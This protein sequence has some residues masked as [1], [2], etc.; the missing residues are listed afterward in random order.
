MGTIASILQMGT[1]KPPGPRG[2][3][4]LHSSHQISYFKSEGVVGGGGCGECPWPQLP[5]CPQGNQAG[6]SQGAQARLV[7]SQAPMRQGMALASGKS[8]WAVSLLCFSLSF[9][10]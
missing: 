10:F 8:H 2:T 3:L 5:V 9:F 7:Q 6:L 4:S 1:R